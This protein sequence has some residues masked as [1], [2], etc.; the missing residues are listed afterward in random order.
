MSTHNRF[1]RICIA[2]IIAAMLLTVL[3]MN[4]EALGIQKTVD[5]DAET[6]EG[7]SVFTANDL[8]GSWDTAKA[9]KITLS[10]DD[11][12][13]SGSGAYVLDGN[14]V[15]ANGGYYVV[16]GELSDGSIVVDAYDS[17][18][19]WILLDG[20]SVQCSDDACL[21]VDQA[22]KVFLTL[23]EGTENTFSSGTE[24]SEEALE[25]GTDGVIFSHDDL[26]INGSG[27]LTVTGGN[28][29]GIACNDDLVITGGTISVEASQDAIHANDSVRIA[30]GTLT[31]TAGDDG[32]AVA[33]EN[34]YLYVEDGEITIEAADDAVHAAGDIT[35]LDGTLTISAGD[36][37]IHSDTRIEISDGTILINECY[38][39][40]EAPQIDMAGGDVTIHPE[41]DGLNANGGSSGFGMGMMGHGMGAGGFSRN[42][43]E[44]G[45]TPTADEEEPAETTPSAGEEPAEAAEITPSAGEEPAE[46][47]ETTP[48]AGEKE[49]P[50]GGMNMEP[51]NENESEETPTVTISGGTLTIVN[52]NGRD[53]D[54]IDSNGDIRITGGTVLVSLNG[55]G[56]NNALDYGSENGGSCIIDGGSVLASGGSSML[57]EISDES[58]QPSVTYVL[59]A[60]TDDDSTVVITDESGSEIFSQTVPCGFTAV[61]ISIP[62]LA[63]GETY[64]LSV[65]ETEEE[66]T[67][68]QTVISSG[69]AGGMNHGGGMGSMNG[70]G[71][72]DFQGSTETG[73]A[74]GN[75]GMNGRHGSH[76][77]QTSENDSTETSERPQRPE[78]MEIQDGTGM[79]EMTG[80]P[81]EGMPE[82]TG[83]P[84]MPENGEFPEMTGT[85]G[86][87]MPEMTGTPGAE[88]S[89]VRDGQGMHGDDRTVAEEE[90]EEE[91]ELP[92]GK[93]LSE[94]G[95]D[96][97]LLLG[98]SVL[99]IAAGIVTGALYRRRRH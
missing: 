92:S 35:I 66:I 29:H 18:K 13:I 38:E 53:S 2:V 77:K 7:S 71:R 33:G 44:D 99:V 45:I 91:G 11:A 10:G 23:G 56:S 88:M 94:Y 42:T 83:M 50:A 55:S 69:A 28:K 81:G 4:G 48:S 41:D 9:V 76:K 79:P 26:T 73:E 12:E 64:T 78:G 51:A 43:E 39:G 97:W 8:D 21:R 85:P 36:D 32:L 74:Q 70:G 82:M 61:T 17:S 15:I 1:D 3:F 80:T 19:V 65:G 46:A 47:A 49:A 72:S 96:T 59:T 93:A 52:A 40:I 60:Q 16:S 54:G 67:F 25:D 20:V 6:Y 31:L 24:Y 63:V 95:R 34:G 98:A 37:G 84:E 86:E 5:E 30:A 75:G 57:E 89:E 58:E 14:V 90:A 62:E 27:S 68:D 87:G 22:D